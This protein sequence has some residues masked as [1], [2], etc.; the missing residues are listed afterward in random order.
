MSR[1]RRCSLPFASPALV[2]GLLASMLVACASDT[3]RSGSVTDPPKI[4][5]RTDSLPYNLPRVLVNV[6]I[7][8]K[9]VEGVAQDSLTV[10]DP[11]IV[12][13]PAHQYR[14][15]YDRSVFATDKMVFETGV[16]GLLTTINATTEDETGDLVAKLAELAAQVA[17]VAVMLAPDGRPPIAPFKISKLVDPSDDG[18]SRAVNGW[19]ASLGA[20]LVFESKP[21]GWRKEDLAAQKKALAEAPA[22]QGVFFRPVLPY[23]LSLRRAS[24]ATIAQAA[25]LAPN[26]AP[27][28][29]IRL[30][31]FPFVRANNTL[32]FSQGLLTKFEIDKPSEALGFIQIPIDVAKAIVDIPGQLLQMKVQSTTNETGLLEAQKALLEARRALEETEN[33]SKP[34]DG[35][36]E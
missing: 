36:S 22:Q 35:A 2:A 33:P 15:Y 18:E 30:E 25:V 5:S 16:S 8:R 27:I 32:T 12:P 17:K 9:V 14:L 6:T 29:G 20:D 28:L 23:V 1:A 24:G 21:M 7:E 34:A 31:R 3:V 19:L 10:G 26:E 13:D 11:V 4:W